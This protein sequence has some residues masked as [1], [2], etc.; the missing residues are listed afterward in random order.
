M[1]L[2]SIEELTN[3]FP[4]ELVASTEVLA[5]AK[6]WALW[7]LSECHSGTALYRPALNTQTKEPVV[8]TLFPLLMDTV[9][10]LARDIRISSVSLLEEWGT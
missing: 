2:S 9:V 1:N 7:S 4:D 8:F 6:V 5:W 10:A 3:V